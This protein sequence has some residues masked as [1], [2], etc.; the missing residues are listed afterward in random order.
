MLKQED[1]NV[2]S[3]LGNAPVYPERLVTKYKKYQVRACPLD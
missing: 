3:I 1:K 2:L